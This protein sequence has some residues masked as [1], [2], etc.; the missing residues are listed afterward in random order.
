MFPDAV[1][2]YGY[3]ASTIVLVATNGFLVHIAILEWQRFIYAKI[4]GI[5][6]CQEKWLVRWIMK[7]EHNK[8]DI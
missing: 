2:K 3:Y 6:L 1:H 7:I 4:C 5:A 8:S